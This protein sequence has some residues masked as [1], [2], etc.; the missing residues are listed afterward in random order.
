MVQ[1]LL[2]Y[3]K[4][5]ITGIIVFVFA[6]LVVIVIWGVIARNLKISAAWVIDLSRILIVWTSFL[7]GGLCFS[8]K[9]HLGV[10]YF[11]SKFGEKVRFYL[12]L[13]VEALN[14]LFSFVLIIGG[15]FLV[16][17]MF[18]Y[19]QTLSSINVKQ[20]W[21][22]LAVPACG[23]LVFVFSLEHVVLLFIKKLTGRQ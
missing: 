4:K 23:V 18:D 5:F 22:Y 7:A 19:G 14:I 16:S 17:S 8:Y 13:F 6:L 3:F 2:D 15:A 11:V 12:D 21:V 9:R 10:D 20:A 1:K